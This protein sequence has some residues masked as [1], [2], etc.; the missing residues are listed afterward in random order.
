MHISEGCCEKCTHRCICL[1]LTYS[2]DCS[3]LFR[4]SL[5]CEFCGNEKILCCY[6]DFE[7]HSLVSLERHP[8][9]RLSHMLLG[10]S[11]PHA[12]L[13]EK[14][15][16]SAILACSQASVGF[17]SIPVDVITGPLAHP[18]A[19]SS[20]QPGASPVLTK[21]LPLWVRGQTCA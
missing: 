11:W 14:S 12:S 21:S 1:L 3:L 7:L 10:Q 19:W 6:G 4:S 15:K 13:E 2:S 16:D 9:R 17:R 20:S 8:H 5:P 18:M